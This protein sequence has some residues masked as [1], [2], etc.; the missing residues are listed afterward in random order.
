MFASLPDPVLQFL[1]NGLQQPQLASAAAISLQNICSQ[2]SE[3][4][5]SHFSGLLQIVQAVDSFNV[6]NDV[7][8]RLL[9]GRL[10][11]EVSIP[12]CYEKGENVPPY[13]IS[14]ALRKSSFHML[15][16]GKYIFTRV[17]FLA[18]CIV[19]FCSLFL[20]TKGGGLFFCIFMY[21]FLFF[22]CYFL[23]DY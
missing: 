10:H 2:C 14:D 6:P 17:L 15:R 19:L 1:M 9:K 12:N 13:E 16:Y 5:T 20:Y 7:A 23:S 22:S 4:M 11:T 18:N 3:H 8:I 21:F